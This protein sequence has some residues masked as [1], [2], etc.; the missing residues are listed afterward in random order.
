MQ[1]HI[2]D[3]KE[4]RKKNRRHLVRLG[5]KVFW[6]QLVTLW[7]QDSPVQCE[8]CRYDV[9]CWLTWQGPGQQL[10]PATC[11]QGQ[12]T[13][14]LPHPDMLLSKC[15]QVPQAVVLAFSHPSFSEFRLSFCSFVHSTNIYLL[16]IVWQ[17]HHRHSSCHCEQDRGLVSGAGI[18]LSVPASPLCFACPQSFP[19]SA[20]FSHGLPWGGSFYFYLSSPPTYVP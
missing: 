8:T 13:M 2:W 17:V 16:P 5:V 10:F 14:L 6:M 9:C 20:F 4:S 15:Y 11:C 12:E 19:P 1:E 7:S 3:L 18:R